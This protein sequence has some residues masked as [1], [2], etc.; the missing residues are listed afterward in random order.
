MNIVIVSVS[1]SIAVVIL[2][3]LGFVFGKLWGVLLAVFVLLLI[4]VG[5]YVAEEKSMKAAILRRAG[6]SRKAERG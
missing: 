4:L 1:L 3:P 6:R 5:L 2:V